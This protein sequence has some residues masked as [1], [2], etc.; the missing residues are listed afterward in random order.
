MKKF[1]FIFL[2]LFFA[3][4]ANGQEQYYYSYKFRIPLQETEWILLIQEN[5]DTTDS[6]NIETHLFETNRRTYS[7]VNKGDAAERHIKI[8]PY[9]KPMMVSCSVT[10]MKLFCH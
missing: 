3:S 8:F 6:L 9:I 1:C 4:L 10:Q 5:E 2:G 7:L